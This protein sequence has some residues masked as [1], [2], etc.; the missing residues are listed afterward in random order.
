V[1]LTAT[2]RGRGLGR[3]RQRLIAAAI[4]VLKEI[5]PATV[6]A[7]CYRLF[8]AGEIASMEVGETQRVGRA[9]VWAREHEEIPWSWIVDE[10]RAPERAATWESPEAFARAAVAS[11]RPDPWQAQG[12]RVEVWSEKGTVRGTLAPVLRR[13]A[14][15]FRVFHGFG[16][17]TALH[18]AAEQSIE[19]TRPTV[20][21]YVGDWDPSGLHMS[22]VDIPARL[23]RYGGGL[24]AFRRIALDVE[25]IEDPALPFFPAASK[26]KDPRWRW[27]TARYG[28][29]CWELDALSPVVFRE[30]VAAMIRAMMP[31][32]AAFARHEATL[33]AE[34]ESIQSALAGWTKLHHEAK[35]SGGDA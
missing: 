7:V 30:R 15:D 4:E 9:L 26:R 25:D 13:Y 6:R 1:G 27:F 23:A 33:A 12:R 31:D 17:A 28:G 24:E 22:E 29:R 19:D 5:A 10:T 8:T 34:R 18:A 32:P 14:I 21:L 2:R 35:S 20:V 3:A 16:S 11:W